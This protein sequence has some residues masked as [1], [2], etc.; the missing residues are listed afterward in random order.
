M[1]T[2]LLRII[3]Y[4]IQS[5]V[6]NGTLSLATIIVIILALSTFLGLWTMNV[7]TA[8]AIHVLQKKIDI[9]IYFQKT[10]RED[11]IRKIQQVVQKLPEVDTTIYI[12]R[13]KALDIFKQKHKN[14]PTIIKA[15]DELGEN[16][17]AASLNIKAK[18][19][20]DYAVIAAYFENEKYKSVIEKVTYDQSQR[21]INRLTKIIDT[22]NVVGVGANIIFALIAIIITFNTVRLAIYANKEEIG[23]MR[24]VGASNAYIRGPYLIEGILYGMI[25]TLVVFMLFIPIIHTINPYIAIII[26]ELSL[27][28][29]FYSHIFTLLSATLAFGIALGTISSTFAITRYLKV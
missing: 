8:E 12:S 22:M 1:A 19:P 14:D 3:K 18:D 9:S 16:P 21:A 11:A 4:G 17:L 27:T 5:F 25:G 23:I 26:P 28:M 2:T 7:I 10:A 6:R 24:L 15:L 13:E 29:Y 20:R